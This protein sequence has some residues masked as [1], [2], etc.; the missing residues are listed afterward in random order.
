MDNETQLIRLQQQQ[1][2]VVVQILDAERDE[3]PHGSQNPPLL[4]SRRARNLLRRWDELDRQIR[5]ARHIESL[6]APIFFLAATN[7]E[8]FV[9]NDPMTLFFWGQCQ[10]NYPNIA[11]INLDVPHKE[12]N[13]R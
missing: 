8:E 6:L 10:K 3:T 13:N 5:C 7:D 1:S 9:S 2:R 4:R 11:G 12:V